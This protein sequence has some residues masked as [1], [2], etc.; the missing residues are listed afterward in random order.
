MREILHAEQPC[1]ICGTLLEVVT[2]HR[3]DDTGEER[4]ER[5]RSVHSDRECARFR[6]LYSE[7]WPTCATGRS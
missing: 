2:I 4:V 3:D 7:E 5:N 6:V 1:I